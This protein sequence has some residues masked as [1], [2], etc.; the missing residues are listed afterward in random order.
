MKQFVDLARYPLDTLETP[1]GG[2]LVRACRRSL[3]QQAHALLPAFLTLEARAAMAAEVDDLLSAAHQQDFVRTPYSWRDNDGFES[4]HPRTALFRECN[5]VVTTEQLPE[6]A[7][8]RG[9]YQWDPLTEF[10]GKTL[11]LAALY[12]SEDPNL[13]ISYNVLDEGDEVAWHFD[14]NQFIVTIMLQAADAGGEFE[15][16]PYVR[17]EE[18]DNYDE[19]ARVFAGDSER[20]IRPA[21]VPGDLMI[22]IGRGTAHRVTPVLST[23]QPRM[24]A[25][26]VYEP[27]SGVLFP[28]ATVKAVTVADSGALSG[29]P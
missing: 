22:F 16:A 18:D 5:R 1:A 26:L 19:V 9:L 8:L 28:R 11:G 25:L 17:S 13:S 3:E 4:G 15:C 27:R 29:T 10:I 23:R 2:E 24:M 6:Q 14:S 7:L 12:R 21:L 20:T